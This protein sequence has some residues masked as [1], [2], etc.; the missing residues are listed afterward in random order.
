MNAYCFVIEYWCLLFMS[1]ISLIACI[2]LSPL[3]LHL[4][5]TVVSVQHHSVVVRVVECHF[6]DCWLVFEL[7]SFYLFKI[8]LRSTQWSLCCLALHFLHIMMAVHRQSAQQQFFKK[9]RGELSSTSRTRGE[10]SNRGIYLVAI[11]W[12]FKFVNAAQHKIKARTL[13]QNMST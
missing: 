4:P 1:H 10:G 3:P 6:A 13:F 5:L 11:C 12:L 9:V 8:N 2:Y 7:L